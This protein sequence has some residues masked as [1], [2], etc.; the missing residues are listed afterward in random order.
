M[1]VFGKTHFFSCL[2]LLRLL[3]GYF[4]ENIP[5]QGR[6]V[7]ESPLAFVVNKTQSSEDLGMILLKH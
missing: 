7:L 5:R 6:I 4:G 2:L 1:R 3:A